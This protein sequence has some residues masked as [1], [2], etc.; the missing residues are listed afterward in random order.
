MEQ[1]TISL[2]RNGEPIWSKPATYLHRIT[3]FET[4]ATLHFIGGFMMSLRIFKYSTDAI[5]YMGETYASRED[6]ARLEEKIS[7]V[8]E[9]KNLEY[10]LNNI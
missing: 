3:I 7:L 6:L 2:Y 10:I 9:Q 4:Y 5:R 8:K 1:H